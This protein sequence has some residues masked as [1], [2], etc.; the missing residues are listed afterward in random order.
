MFLIILIDGPKVCTS[1]IPIF[2]SELQVCGGDLSDLE[3]IEAK[4]GSLV[5]YYYHLVGSTSQLCISH[6]R[7]SLDA[8]ITQ[9]YLQCHF[10]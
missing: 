3:V 6:L 4:I 7:P 8:Y 9:I 5:C 1:A 10:Q 2:V